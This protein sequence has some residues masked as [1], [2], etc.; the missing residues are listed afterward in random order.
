MVGTGPSGSTLRVGWSTKD[1]IGV[2]AERKNLPLHY[3]TSSSIE[4]VP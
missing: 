3:V 1:T 4:D 2:G